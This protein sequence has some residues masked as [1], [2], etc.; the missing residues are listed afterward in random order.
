MTTTVVTQF[1][2]CIYGILNLLSLVHFQ[3]VRSLG[4]IRSCRWIMAMQTL[5][6]FKGKN[7]WSMENSF[8]KLLLYF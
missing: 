8:G 1:S 4:F 7:A 3:T 6:P 2:G 5:Y